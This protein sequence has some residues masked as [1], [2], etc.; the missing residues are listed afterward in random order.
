MMD[1]VFIRML[2][3]EKRATEFAECKLPFVAYF[4][5]DEIR[6]APREAHDLILG[7]KIIQK[8]LRTKTQ[9]DFTPIM[10]HPNKDLYEDITPVYLRR[11]LP[12]M[13]E[14]QEEVAPEK[15][16]ATACALLTSTEVVTNVYRDENGGLCAEVESVEPTAESIPVGASEMIQEEVDTNEIASLMQKAVAVDNAAATDANLTTTNVELAPQQHLQFVNVTDVTPFG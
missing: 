9:P 15:N 12:Q 4:T 7:Y 5:R 10:T 16:E 14:T 8:A 3:D 1:A 11:R 6:Y 2:A 13:A